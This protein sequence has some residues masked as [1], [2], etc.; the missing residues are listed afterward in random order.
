MMRYMREKLNA[1]RTEAT[2]QG[3]ELKEKLINVS[4]SYMQSVRDHKANIA[5]DEHRDNQLQDEININP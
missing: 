4:P 5:F 2:N 1:T 3:E